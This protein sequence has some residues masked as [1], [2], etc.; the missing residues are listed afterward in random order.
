MRAWFAGDLQ[1]FATRF[2]ACLTKHVARPN[3]GRDYRVR[4]Q[5]PPINDPELS[6]QQRSYSPNDL[7]TVNEH[8]AADDLP[9]MEGG[10]VVP[11]VFA[12]KQQQAMGIGPDGQPLGGDPND[13]NGGAVAGG[14][15]MSGHPLN[16]VGDSILGALGVQGGD[17]ASDPSNDPF[18][19]DDDQ[20]ADS[21]PDDTDVMPFG[22]AFGANRWDEGKHKRD[23][24]K[25]SSTQGVGAKGNKPAPGAL[26]NVG[27]RSAQQ[28]QL[29][30]NVARHPKVQATLQH[31]T[32]KAAHIGQLVNAGMLAN[33]LSPE[34]IIGDQQSWAMYFATAHADVLAQTMHVDTQTAF[35][36]LSHLAAHGVSAIKRHLTGG[37]KPAAAPSLERPQPAGNTE[38]VPRPDATGGAGSLP[39]RLKAFLP[40]PELDALLAELS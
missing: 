33:G 15:D 14:E 32:D 19:G 5:L 9:P 25:F 8:R 10:D 34:S 24:G 3:Y 4:L 39:N 12:A 13:P 17:G 23:G 28:S 37:G 21:D 11:S 35:A 36:V 16:A 40:V 27:Q 1:P 22:K 20:D 29:P 6:I 38:A 7:R 31:L 2:S 30:P 18:G 26:G